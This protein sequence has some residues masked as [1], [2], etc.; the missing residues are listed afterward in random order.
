MCNDI[1]N[2]SEPNLASES[3]VTEK[4]VF[5]ELDSYFSNDKVGRVL[6]GSKCGK[7]TGLDNLLNEYFVKFKDI[8]Q[9]SLV[10]LFNC[11]LASS[12][13]P[14]VWSW[15]TIVPLHKKADTNDTNDRHIIIGELL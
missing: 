14:R 5:L 3:L 6:N 8:F 13:F 1:N 10:L 2:A 4:K 11:I 12:V 7:A 15:G 9:Q